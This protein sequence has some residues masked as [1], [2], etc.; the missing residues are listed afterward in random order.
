MLLNMNQLNPIKYYLQEDVFFYTSVPNMKP[1]SY[2][3]TIAEIAIDDAQVDVWPE[4]VEYFHNKS[5]VKT[6][7][8]VD[9][10]Y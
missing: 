10:L 5:D 3:M 6:G 7:F 9:K 1:R 4:D 2:E 8:E